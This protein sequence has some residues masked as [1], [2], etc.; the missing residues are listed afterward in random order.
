MSERFAVSVELKDQHDGSLGLR[1]R[2]T[3]E[4]ARLHA[5]SGTIVLT[6]WTEADG[7]VRAR[8]E[9]VMSGATSYL[10]GN[11]TMVRFSSALGL[12]VSR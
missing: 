6:V 11:E 1:V 3:E 10:Q 4:H 7:I 5:D 8:F 9:H 2:S 12:R